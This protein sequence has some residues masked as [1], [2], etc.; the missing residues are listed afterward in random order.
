MKNLKL[1]ALIIFAL[2]TFGSCEK[3][4]IDTDLINEQ[5]L[6]LNSK[7]AENSKEVYTSK[8]QNRVL[9][10]EALK[11]D[12]VG[13]SF[14]RKLQI[15]T[16]PGYKKNGS[17]QY[18]VV[19][20]LHGEPFS[21]KAYIDEGL[22][23]EWINQSPLWTQ[24]PDFPEEGFR[25]WVDN[26]IT[27]NTIEPMIIVMPDASTLPYGFSFYTNSILNGNFEDFIVNDL[28]NYMDKNYNTIPDAS[29]RAVIGH[30]QGGYAAFKFGMKHPDIFKTVASHSGL[31][32]VDALFDPSFIYL[33]EQE[34]QGGFTGP[35][36]TKFLTSAMYAMSAAWS[37]NLSN[38]PF[39]VNLP[40]EFHSD[41]HL[42][43]RPEIVGIWYQNDVFH[44]L[45]SYHEVFNSLNGIYL[46]VGLFDELGTQLAHEPL[47]GKLDY[48]NIGY[49]FK[50][51][52]G[53]HHTHLFAQLAT[54][55]AFCS[56]SMNYK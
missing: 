25:L 35:D 23:Q 36:P 17:I 11:G 41:G 9:N 8:L 49:T 48:Y 39:Y 50:T 42:Y 7:K 5:S 14:T 13:N 32:F 1:L 38:P 12:F 26:L 3:D 53:G 10:S 27:Q 29:G 2:L 33:L 28:V 15:Y 37:P 30:S 56:N 20:L 34:N 4:S 31:L 45:D 44:L 24:Y 52:E 54:S 19:Y 51:Y 21:E 16:P 22:F 46:D 6:N 40:L 47:I 18:P 55:L 43:P